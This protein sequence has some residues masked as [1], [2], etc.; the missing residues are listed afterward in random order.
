MMVLILS[1][2]S[3]APNLLP[4]FT[5]AGRSTLR[6]ARSA[7]ADHHRFA[8]SLRGG[9][10]GTRSIVLSGNEP[11]VDF[12]TSDMCPYAQ[13]CWIVLEA[14]SVPYNKTVIDLMDKPDWYLNEVNPRGKVPAIR[15]RRDGTVVFESLVVAEF[16]VERFDAD[17]ASGLMPADPAGRALVRRWNA[18]LDSALAPAQFTLLMNKDEDA[19]GQKRAA[20]DAALAVFEKELVGPFLCG[21]NFTVADAVALPFFERLVVGIRGIKGF[22][23]VPP[24]RY[25]RLH[26]YLEQAMEHPSFAVTKRPE[27]ALVSLYRAFVDRDYAFGGLNRNQKQ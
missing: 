6:F 18:H 16:L 20:L 27:E 2:L 1:L 10:F 24:D 9:T 21:M 15:D 26:A 14:L 23:P 3:I 8:L 19:E 5:P 11:L 25:P 22:D 12:F 7:H 4:A 17:G 13:R